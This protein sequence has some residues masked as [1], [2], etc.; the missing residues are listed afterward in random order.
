MSTAMPARVYA[1]RRDVYATG[2]IIADELF[3]AQI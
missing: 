3:A 1:R 2:Q